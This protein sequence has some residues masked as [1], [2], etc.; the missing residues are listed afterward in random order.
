MRSIWVWPIMMISTALGLSLITFGNIASPIRPVIA[1][2]FLLV[3][4]GMAFVRLLRI[5]E[6]LTELM[7]AVALSLAIDTLVAEAILYAEIWSS[8]LALLVLIGISVIGAALQ[9]II[10]RSPVVDR[11]QPQ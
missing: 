1:F 3:C 11:P 4:P 5:R 8:R 7:L 2:W 10:L 9:L 6:T